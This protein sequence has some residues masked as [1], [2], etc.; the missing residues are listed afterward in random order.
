[1]ASFISSKIKTEQSEEKGIGS[2]AIDHIGKG[3][4]VIVQS[5]QI[6]ENSRLSGDDF[7]QFFYHCFQIDKDFSICPLELSREK[8]DGIFYVNH[9]CEPNCG[10]RGQITLVALRDICPGEEIVYDYVMTDVNYKDEE[11]GEMKC[12]CKSADCRG[13]ITGEDWKRKDLQ[14]KYKG[15]FSD[16]TQKA[17]DELS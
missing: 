10:F 9:S 4:V 15:Y 17:I 11:W 12:V 14:E 2:F 7:E 8:M 3:E 5:G 16:H 13:A 6:V 1:M